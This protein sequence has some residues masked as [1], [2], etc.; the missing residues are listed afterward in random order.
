MRKRINSR[1]KGKAGELEACKALTSELGVEARRGQQFRGG[2]D[3]PDVRHGLEGVHI[4]VKRVERLNLA[5]AMV[6]AERDADGDIPVVLSRK[7]LHPWLVT[8]PLDRLL[9]L[10]EALRVAGCEKKI[11]ENSENSL[12]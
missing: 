5:E 4:E 12:E 11:P 8:V 9:G 1:R 6:Q 2:P 3:S 10:A 7:N